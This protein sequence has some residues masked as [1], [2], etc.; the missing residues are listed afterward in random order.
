MK[1]L[2]RRQQVAMDAALAPQPAVQFGGREPAAFVPL[3]E[4]P[5]WF[6]GG[7]ARPAVG[8]SWGGMRNT[9]TEG[10][11]KGAARAGLRSQSARGFGTAPR[12]QRWVLCRHTTSLGAN[13]CRVPR[14]ICC[15]AFLWSLR[16]GF[17]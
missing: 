3:L 11:I 10:K 14:S 7:C 17:A 16:H 2:Y 4:P 6:Y 1:R 5:W 9:Q 15:A 12:L 13:A 8:G